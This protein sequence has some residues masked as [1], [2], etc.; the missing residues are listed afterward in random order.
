MI[1]KMFLMYKIGG[2][3]EGVTFLNDWKILHLGVVKT[4]HEVNN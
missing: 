2:G 1:S 4:K 3:G